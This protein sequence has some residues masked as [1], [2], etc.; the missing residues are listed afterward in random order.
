[1]AD[2]AKGFPRGGLKA[3]EGNAGVALGAGNRE[4]RQE[5]RRDY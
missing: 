3:R 1:M 5:K 2:A 4:K